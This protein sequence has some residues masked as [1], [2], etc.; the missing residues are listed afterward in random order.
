MTTG[1][2]PLHALLYG[3]VNLNIIDG[4]AIWAQSMAEALS[5][6]GCRVTMV[7][8]ARVLT[9]RLVAPI[10]SLPNVTVIRAVE[11]GM[12]TGDAVTP[13]QLPGALSRVDA[14]DHADLVVMR[15]LRA[16]TAVV[17]EGSLNGRLWTY[18]TDVPQDPLALDQATTE[19]LGSISAASRVM[20][21][22]T[23]ELRCHLESA[24][25][26]ACGNSEIWS[27]VVPEPTF[28]IPEHSDPRDGVRMVYSGKFAPLWNTM[29]MC[30]LPSMLHARGIDAELHMVGDKVHEDPGDPTFRDRM[31]EALRESPGVLW[32]GGMPRQAA[33]QL[34]ATGHVGLGW[35]DPAMDASLE[36]STKVLEFGM[37]G[38]PVIFNRTTMHERLFGTDYP[39]YA[40]S[41]E[42]VAECVARLTTDPQ[43]A[44]LARQRCADVAGESSMPRAIAR[45]RGL[46]DRYFPS[47]PH[48]ASRA[49][50]LRVLVAS[51]DLKFFTRIL[52]H[53]RAL[54]ELEVRVDHWTGLHTH[55]E[56]ASRGLLDWAEVVVCEW[57]G[58]NAVWYSRNKRPGQRLITRLHRFELGGRWLQEIDIAAVDQVV[59]VSPHYAQLTRRQTGWDPT[60]VVVVPNWVDVA[61]FD[62]PKL[63]DV[64]HSLGMIGIAPARKR[65]DLG[66]E[67][68]S[69]LRR[70][71]DR[72]RL[73][74]KS[75]MP[76]DYWWIWNDRAEHE[77][78]AEVF[79]R[80]ARSPELAGAVVFDGFGGDVPGWLRRIGWVLS[81]S[82]DESFHLAPAEGMASR[83][84]PAL[85]PW[86]GSDTI[87][88]R[89]WISPDAAAMAARIHEVVS[90]GQWQ[91]LADHAHRS[92]LASFPL[93]DVVDRWTRILTED[94]PAGSAEGTLARPGA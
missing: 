82:D 20:L 23:E 87:Y 39:F 38:V 62:R 56:A 61:Q 24:I 85:L 91:Q 45:M 50:R 44:D 49:G 59:C 4:S 57:A 34:A 71:D 33:M 65:L 51:H 15:G 84:V 94:V 36:L 60:R 18:L 53:Y 76:W 55:D 6:A 92:V 37:L 22:Q 5:G 86:P 13:G 17:A 32:H 46:L 26:Q 90:S 3:D 73:S 43:A 88:A 80:V 72:Y 77:H 83:A 8:K 66:V 48:L 16:V 69:H 54:P 52:D 70:W 25:P 9:D 79:A 74:I 93:A 35:R 2:R 28:P 19:T 30:Q 67:V 47:A 41:L 31:S 29:Q 10:E 40:A 58:P 12:A 21:C 89:E 11:A 14:A 42:D 68:L 63:G 81:T 1:N 75:K 64:R 27:P 7:L 78:F